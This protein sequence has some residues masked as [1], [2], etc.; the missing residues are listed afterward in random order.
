MKI[1]LVFQDWIK[2][3][4][5]IYQTSEGVDL[6]M[7]VFHSGTTFDGYIEIDECDEKELVKA[8]NN[9]AEPVFYVVEH[10]NNKRLRALEELTEQ[11]QELDMGY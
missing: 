10:I 6:S 4:K 1:K 9:G 3:G 11:A 2:G 7:G 8:M 5:S